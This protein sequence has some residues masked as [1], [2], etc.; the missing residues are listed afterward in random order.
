MLCAKTT[1]LRVD[2][3][4]HILQDHNKR[5]KFLPCSKCKGCRRCYSLRD[6]RLARQLKIDLLEHAQGFLGNDAEYVSSVTVGAMPGAHAQ[7]W[8][9]DT[10]KELKTDMNDIYGCMFV[11]A[12][13]PVTTGFFEYLP[14]SARDESYDCFIG[15]QRR[16][17]EA[18][19][20]DVGPV[21]SGC[22]YCGIA[23]IT[24]TSYT[25]QLRFRDGYIIATV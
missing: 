16:I 18:C 21:G 24:R 25:H 10:P 4:Q 11:F 9:T 14:N 20:T 12:L 2:T 17:Q 23:S 22:C 19:K 8:H 3:V 1:E 13:T 6:G 15:K 5:A 7:V